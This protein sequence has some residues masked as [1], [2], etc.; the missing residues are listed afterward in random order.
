MRYQFLRHTDIEHAMTESAPA[1]I[2]KALMIKARPAR[3]WFVLTT[4]D[5]MQ[6]WMSNDELTIHSE[7]RVGS[8]ICM[9]GT[10]HG[11]AFENRGTI[12]QFEPEKVF[13]YDYWSTLLRSRVVD[14]PENYSVVRVE[15]A[16]T[17]GGTL[18]TLALSNIV[19]VS[20]YQHANFYWTSAL[21]VLKTV[22]ERPVSE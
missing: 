17:S 5:L 21:Q 20:I 4:P 12:H 6:R 19:D 16:A 1:A 15:L 13:E 22:C 9:Q 10:L 11:V 3:V 18:L 2:S 8:P 14:S 7:W